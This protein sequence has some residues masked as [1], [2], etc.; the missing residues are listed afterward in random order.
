MVEERGR[1][2]KLR[3]AKAAVTYRALLS[4]NEYTMNQVVRVIQAVYQEHRARPTWEV[5]LADAY[6]HF[7]RV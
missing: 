1:D 5:N 6:N 4:W 2:D 3:S 7:Y